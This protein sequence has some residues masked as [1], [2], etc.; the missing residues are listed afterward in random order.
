MKKI[1][2]FL[3]VVCAAVAANAQ[4]YAGGSLG[5]WDNDDA[6]KTSFRIVP[7]VGYTLDDKWALGI[8]LGY[9]HSKVAGIKKDIYFVAPYARYSYFN[10]GIVSLFVDGGF[11][12]STVKDGEDG[13]NIGL[14]PGLAIKL[15]DKFSLV[16]KFGFVG[17]SDDYEFMENGFGLDLTNNITF[18]FFVNF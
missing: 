7:E 12:F 17:Y 18:G 8:E 13:F 2:M 16:S 11:G 3:F 1:V 5:F 14:K 9:D 6:D 10:K 4:V 15:T